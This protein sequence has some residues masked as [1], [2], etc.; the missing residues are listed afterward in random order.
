MAR[1]SAKD[2]SPEALGAAEAATH[3]LDQEAAREDSAQLQQAHRRYAGSMATIE[4]RTV[5]I[6]PSFS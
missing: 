1:C 5:C 3:A 6:L 2:G 4:E